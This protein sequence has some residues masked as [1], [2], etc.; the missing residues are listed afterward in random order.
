[1]FNNIPNLIHPTLTPSIIFK[2]TKIHLNFQK[3]SPSALMPHCIM[4]KELT[5][6]INL[7]Q[8]MVSYFTSLLILHLIWPHGFPVETMWW[9]SINI[10]SSKPVQWLQDNKNIIHP[11]YWTSSSYRFVLKRVL[12]RKV[13]GLKRCNRSYSL[14]HLTSSSSDT[15]VD[16]EDGPDEYGKYSLR[17]NERWFQSWLEAGLEAWFQY[18]YIMVSSWS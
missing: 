15:I 8:I 18:G 14:C 10:L 9:S 3:K 16:G 17:L 13:Y 1:M 7:I 2:G 5:T 4:L 6:N 11:T 12:S